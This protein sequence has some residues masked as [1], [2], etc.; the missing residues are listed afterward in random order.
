M[1]FVY[2]QSTDVTRWLTDDA[3]LKKIQ[4]HVSKNKE[5]GEGHASM[6]PMTKI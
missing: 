6:V 2:A 1:K 3:S 5:L 4:S